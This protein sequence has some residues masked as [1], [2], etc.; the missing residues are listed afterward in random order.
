MAGSAVA[1]PRPLLP[2]QVYAPYYQTWLPAGITT[3]AQQSGVRYFTLAFVESTSQTSCVPAWNGDP[4]TKVA[5]GRVRWR[6]SP[7]LRKMGGD[8]VPSF[9]GY[10]ADH[11]GTEI[12]DSCNV[13]RPA[14]GGLQVGDHDARRDAAS[15]WTSRIARSAARSRIDRRNKAL[16]QVEDWAA[17]HT[18][19]PADPVH[20]ADRRRTGS[21][22]RP[23]RP[24]ER[25]GQRHPGRR[26]QHH[27]LRLLRRD[28]DRHGRARRS[29]RPRACTA[30]CTRS[31]RRAARHALGDGGK[32]LPERHRRL[33]GEDRGH[34]S[35][36]PRRSRRSPQKVGIS[37]LGMWA[38]Q[39]DNGGCPGVIDS[40]SCSGIEQKQ[41]AFSHLLIPFTRRQHDPPHRI[42]PRPHRAGRRAPQR[43][44]LRRRRAPDSLQVLGP[45]RPHP[46]RR[47]RG[48]RLPRRRARRAVRPG[49][50]HLL[51][52]ARGHRPAGV[53]RRARRPAAGSSHSEATL[54]IDGR[55]RPG[56]QHEPPRR[57]GPTRCSS[58]ARPPA[59]G[60]TCASS[61][62]ATASSAGSTR[63][64]RPSSRS[65][66][67]AARS[68]ASTPS[69]G[70]SS[71]TSTCCAG[72]RPSR[73]TG[74]TPPG[75]AS[76]SP[77]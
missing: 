64:T 1:G 55:S 3:I 13:A 18:P 70:S 40:D 20:A 57:R 63:A 71:T 37:T 77:S 24:Q 32:H 22:R 52:Q 35:P 42:H 39:R 73:A 26:R 58:S 41:W 72:S 51:V 68:P 29:A 19:P 25:Q 66:S 60:S 46:R 14:R 59:S 56:P 6:A 75:P 23:G 2:R 65:C 16:R 10:S 67:T 74:S 44:D 49:L 7:Q 69:R 36:T 45:R 43:A 34:P 47:R 50:D 54:W 27:D 4:S 11:S 17:A 62:P 5:S 30:S 38:I 28:H 53:G 76:C 48:A 31:T 61:S 21:S 8:V 33:P 9:G 12:G 15:T